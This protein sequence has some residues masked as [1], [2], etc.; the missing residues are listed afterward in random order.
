[1][2]CST[3]IRLLRMTCVVPVAV[4]F[5]QATFRSPIEKKA[6]RGENM[7]AVVAPATPPKA[8]RAAGRLSSPLPVA[9]CIRLNS[10]E[11][12]QTSCGTLR[13]LLQAALY[14]NEDEI[15]LTVSPR[16]KAAAAVLGGASV[17]SVRSQDGS[18][19]QSYTLIPDLQ[20][21]WLLPL[22]WYCRRGFS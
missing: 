13:V 10:E 14:R 22:L 5:M 1:M 11:R 17:C 2:T 9:A 16:A 3:S 7:E 21:M 15:S 8:N 4:S 18:H 19:V 6:W 12:L 20:Q